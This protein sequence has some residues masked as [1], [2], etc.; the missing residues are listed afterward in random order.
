MLAPAKVGDPIK[1]NR[2][3]ALIRRSDSGLDS[4][5]IKEVVRGLQA[6]RGITQVSAVTLAANLDIG[7][8]LW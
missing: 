8:Y 6:L 4:P 2:R 1:K 7:Q 5:Q 3:D